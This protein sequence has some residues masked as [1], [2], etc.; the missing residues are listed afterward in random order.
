MIQ[1]TVKYFDDKSSPSFSFI[2]CEPG[3]VDLVI[4]KLQ[5]LKTVKEIHR[6]YGKYDILVK[7]ENMTEP[8]LQEF[9]HD[10]VQNMVVVH[11]V[12]NLTSVYAA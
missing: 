1:Q 8:E 5:T 7:L 10:Q 4:E 11:S 6:T 2:I 9:I 12:M 3:K